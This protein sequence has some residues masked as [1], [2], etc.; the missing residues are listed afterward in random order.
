MK[1]FVCGSKIF[2]DITDT[3]NRYFLGEAIYSSEDRICK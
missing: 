2:T 1:L 3:P